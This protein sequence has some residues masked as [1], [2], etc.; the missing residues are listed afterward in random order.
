M[1]NNPTGREESSQA[2]VYL[3]FTLKNSADLYIQT[4]IDC[5]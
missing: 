2:G 4:R 3:T 1:K 5:K